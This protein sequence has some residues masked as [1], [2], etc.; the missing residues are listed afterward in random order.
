M[1][2]LRVKVLAVSVALVTAL[3][4]GLT[5]SSG[6]T[7]TSATS[8]KAATGGGKVTTKDLANGAVTTAKLAKGAVTTRKIRNGAITAWKIKRHS[9]GKGQIGNDAI[10]TNALVSSAVTTGKIAD[11]AVT[12]SKLAP[13]LLSQLAGFVVLNPSSTQT[14]TY[15][16]AGV[17]T[18]TGS[19]SPA[20][21]TNEPGWPSG[22]AGCNADCSGSA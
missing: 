9:I 5:S 17:A 6:K 14:I 13:G 4:V 19:F 11:G 3:T 21:C 20:T 7:M 2:G 10:T 15:G 8:A 22:A 12:A 1:S 16:G 18:S